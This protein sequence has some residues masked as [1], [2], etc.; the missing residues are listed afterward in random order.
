MC[1]LD[2]AD[3]I[4]SLLNHLFAT[5]WGCLGEFSKKDLSC[6]DTTFL[7]KYSRKRMLLAFGSLQP[8]RPRLG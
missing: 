7:K 4:L 2:F 6:V 8:F 3:W 1:R 5:R